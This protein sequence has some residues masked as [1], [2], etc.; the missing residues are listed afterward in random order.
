[1]TTAFIS[2]AGLIVEIALTRVLSV[3]YLQSYVFL[4]LSVA[5]LGLGLGAALLIWLP[6]L[7][8]YALPW[9]LSLAAFAI[10]GL[11]LLFVITAGASRVLVFSS[12]IAIY[13]CLGIALAQ[14][15]RWHGARST[16]LYLADLSGAAAGVGLALL[17]LNLLGGL[18]ALSFAALLLAVAALAVAPFRLPTAL[19]AA[20]A[21]I[22]AG[23]QLLAPPELPMARLAT[24]KG[25]VTALQR[26]G[27]LITTRWNAFSRTDLVRQDGRWY[28]FMDGGAGSLIPNIH[29]P[30]GWQRDIGSFAFAQAPESVFIIGPGGGLDIALA[31]RAGVTD[32]TAVEINR[33][34]VE[35]TRAQAAVAAGLYDD[36]VMT[37]ID[38]GRSALKR[39]GRR[40]DL[41]FL[42]HVITQAADTRAFVMAENTLYTTQALGDYLDHLT[43]E[44]QIAL[45]LYDE[46]TLTR[47]FFT[48]LEVLAARGLSEAAAAEHLVVV[49]DTRV[50]PAIPLLIVRQQPLAR[51]E[52]VQLARL[53]EAQGYALLFIP[54]LLANPPLDGLLRAEVSA[55]ALISASPLEL[56]P[57]TDDRPFFYKFDPGLPEPLGTLFWSLILLT[58]CL[59][60]GW[61]WQLRR[62]APLQQRLAP[63]IVGLLGAG[64]MMLEVNLVQRAQQ[65]LGHPSWTLGLVAGSVLLGGGLGS[66]LAGWLFKADPWR[67]VRMASVL[68]VALWSLWT[69]SWPTLTQILSAQAFALRAG[70]LVLSI[71]PLALSLGMP[72]PLL[73]TAA[74]RQ[75][76]RQVASAWA[77]SGLT[78]VLGSVTAVAL[79]LTVG[80]SSVAAVVAVLYAGV[81]ALAHGALRS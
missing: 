41:I 76:D 42:S 1:M 11:T 16:V 73:L 46:L 66:Y 34:S 57:V 81:A 28:L 21:L 29:E 27:E 72:F 65:L 18:G 55:Q 20:F 14:L 54:G 58:A 30:A 77:I 53:A 43:P 3:L 47:A 56:R 10:F 26:G 15:F 4:V 59:L 63:I 32:I 5:V 33:A 60:V 35:L 39:L 74:S 50:S 7:K 19:P 25:I 6:P 2:A 71:L 80:F 49:L 62:P 75:S 36:P 31:Q 51:E 22:A 37:L 12:A 69:L 8:P 44:G 68:V 38:E 13:L 24:P 78:S 70:A 67:G 52:A 23:L 64:F 61:L 40:Y 9:L 79:A 17:S 45:K 48:A